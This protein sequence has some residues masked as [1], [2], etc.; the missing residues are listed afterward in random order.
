LILLPCS[1][2]LL[3]CAPRS[4]ERDLAGKDLLDPLVDARLG[5]M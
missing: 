3:R 1:V 5:G 4:V 2:E